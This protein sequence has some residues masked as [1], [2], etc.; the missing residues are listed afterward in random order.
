MEPGKIKC[1]L[2]RSIR[3]Q[4]AHR[5]NIEYIPAECYHVGDCKGTCPACDAELKYLEDCAQVK[6]KKGENI[7]YR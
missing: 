4:F 5:N 1:R 2:L 3:V 6:S 7:I